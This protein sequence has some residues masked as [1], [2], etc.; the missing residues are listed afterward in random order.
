MAKEECDNT[1]AWLSKFDR[2]ISLAQLRKGFFIV[3]ICAW[4]PWGNDGPLINT[5]DGYLEYIQS[6]L[7]YGKNKPFCSGPIAGNLSFG[8][9]LR[10][11]NEPFLF[12]TPANEVRRWRF[13]H[14]AENG[15][16]SSKKRG[17]IGENQVGTRPIRI[18]NLS[19]IL[20]L[21]HPSVRTRATLKAIPQLREQGLLSPSEAHILT[22]DNF[23]YAPLSIILQ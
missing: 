2:R 12:G 18:S 9:E 10:N 17:A 3:W 7:D 13:R 22:N 16:I 4:R 1:P 21:V 20:Q 15:G 8:E 11:K 19:S 5:M 23:F 14:E 6:K